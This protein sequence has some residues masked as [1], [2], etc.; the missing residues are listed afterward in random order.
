MALTFLADSKGEEVT[1]PQGAAIARV[2]GLGT[3]SDSGFDTEDIATQ[4]GA[5]RT[6]DHDYAG[7]CEGHIGSRLFA[8]RCG[9]GRESLSLGLSRD[10]V[11]RLVRTDVGPWSQAS[12]ERELEPAVWPSWSQAG[13]EMGRAR[14]MAGGR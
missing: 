1:C 4:N 12:A 10:G 7:M 13:V 14:R 8:G 2:V 3:D 11:G 6:T 5:L 9:R